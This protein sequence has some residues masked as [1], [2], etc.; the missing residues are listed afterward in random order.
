MWLSTEKLSLNG[1]KYKNQSTDEIFGV[2]YDERGKLV[3]ISNK[4]Q[5]YDQ[6]PDINTEPID[7]ME[8]V[9]LVL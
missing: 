5:V 9:I 2:F 8:D 7:E 6:I 4:G 1:M 3:L